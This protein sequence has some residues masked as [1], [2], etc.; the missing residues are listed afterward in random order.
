[1]IDLH[2]R[3]RGALVGCGIGDAMG[4]PVEGWPAER[5]R[6][7]YGR[8]ESYIAQPDG[9]LTPRLTDDTQMTLCLAGSIVEY[10]HLDPEDLARRFDA[11][12]YVGRGVGRATRE[13]I[14]RYR[15]GLPWDEAG[16]PSS[17]NG[18][19]MR[20]APLGLL[21]PADLNALRRDA[22]LA[23]MITH[24][25]SLATASA[26]AVGADVGYLTTCPAGT[27]T[28]E[29]F[30]DALLQALEGLDDLPYPLSH[31]GRSMS[32]SQRLDQVGQVLDAS[33]EEAFAVTHNGGFVLESLPAAVWSF[34]AHIEDP[35]EAIRTAVN[36]GFDADT[37]AAM[38]GAFA[39]AYHGASGFPNEWV[40][41]LEFADG[42]A[43]WAD[44][45]VALV[46]RAN[47]M[48]AGLRCSTSD[49]THGWKPI[50]IDGRFFPTV[51]HAFRSL[52]AKDPVDQE[53]IRVAPT[54]VDAEL[55]ARAVVPD[56]DA[57]SKRDD[58]MTDLMNRGKK[59]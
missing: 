9:S 40:W 47:P 27:A 44:Q 11:W 20:A 31:L 21:H 36:G 19:A 58:L 2:D 52:T 1:M 29:G 51:E 37:V 7:V 3:Y 6:H 10:G 41:P 43:G 32:L 15:A 8:L 22:R 16:V 53:R 57:W 35:A 48:K 4:S 28:C 59:D 26:A 13:A 45:M 23:S 49:S 12:L 33:P 14:M 42:L 24:N 55:A 34:L 38:T 46:G 54:P 17:G 5:I 50:S 56:I 25:D 30:L 39:G 18:A